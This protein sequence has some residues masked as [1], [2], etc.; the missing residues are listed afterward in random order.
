VPTDFP[1]SDGTL[2]WDKTIIVV[3]QAGAG[4]VCGLGYTDADVATA[5]FIRDHL[6]DV[7]QGH[8]AMAVSRAR[9]AMQKTR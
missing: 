4:G 2:T 5:Q 9:A 3:V 8:D 6:L 1:E 7:L